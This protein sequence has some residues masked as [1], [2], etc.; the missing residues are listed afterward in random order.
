MC[1]GR[2]LLRKRVW[3]H[4]PLVYFDSTIDSTPGDFWRREANSSV[5]SILLG[6][7]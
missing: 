5:S 3:Q 7:A 4:L 2:I 1:A 6:E